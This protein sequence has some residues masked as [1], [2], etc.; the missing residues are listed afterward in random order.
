MEAGVGQATRGVDL[1]NEA[2]QS[3]VSI[4]DGALR[5]V[6][7]VND[8]SSS[9]REQSTTSSEIA[10]NIEQIAQMSEESSQA[11]QNTTEAARR[12]QELSASLHTAVSRFKTS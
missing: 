2:G 7:V 12:L 1:A 4:R 10:R 8:I 5:V 11:V 3:I 9:I 6:A